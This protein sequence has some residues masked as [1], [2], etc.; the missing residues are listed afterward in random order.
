MPTV[1][2][3]ISRVDRK[4]LLEHLAEELEWLMRERGTLATPDEPVTRP[5]VSG[6]EQCHRR[7]LTRG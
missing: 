6:I 1:G 2:D 5:A 3:L 4:R 7:Y